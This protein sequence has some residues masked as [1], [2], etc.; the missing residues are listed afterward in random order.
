MLSRA[1]TMYTR[2]VIAIALL[3]C[4]IS[5]A[6]GYSVYA[7]WDTCEA[8]QL[9]VAISGISA[10]VTI[11]LAIVAV[12]DPIP[13]A[14]TDQMTV[15]N[16]SGSQLFPL[17]PNTIDH[18]IYWTDANSPTPSKILRVDKCAF[19]EGDPHL[20][21]FD[22]YKFDYQG[23]CA[24]ILVQDCVQQ[25][26]PSFAITGYFRSNKEKSPYK[27]RTRMVS[28]SLYI[29]GELTVTLLED[30]TFEIRGHRVFD[31]S[32]TIGHKIGNVYSANGTTVVRLRKPFLTI[33][34]NG[35][36]HKNMI[37]INDDSLRGKVC[38]LLGN[39]DGIPDNDFVK[40]NGTPAHDSEEFGKSWQVPYSCL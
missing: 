13:N 21:T 23:V 29:E 12:N 31:T 15:Q 9:R 10:P 11:D 20:L 37:A 39:A 19:I 8:K 32:A 34:W 27:G 4:G 18:V 7:F 30:N 26:N 16:P 28:I 2:I 5:G 6:S 35:K 25:S 36:P 38:G 17:S 22:G 40:P 3:M 24:Y 1:S 33:T 14:Y